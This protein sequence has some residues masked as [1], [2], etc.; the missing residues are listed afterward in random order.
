MKNYLNDK[1]RIIIIGAILLLIILAF[2]ISSLLQPVD[3][4]QAEVKKFVIPKGQAISIIGE[5]LKDEGFIKSAYAFRYI[6]ARDDLSTKI[7]AGS[8]DLSPNMSVSEIAKHLT[9]GTED[10]WITILEGWR[11]EEIAASLAS[12]DLENF[13]ED[14]FLALAKDSEG[15]LYPDTYLIPREMTASQIYNLLINTFER[16]ITLGLKDEIESS[17]KDFDQILIMA[18][19]LEREARTPDQMRRVAGILWNRIEIGM[20][21]QVDATLQYAKGYDELNQSWWV[22]P[23]S[24]DKQLQSPYN[25]YLNPGLPPKPISN[26]GL[27]AIKAAMDPL[28]SDDIFYIHSDDGM[29]YYSQ[30]L[31]GHNANINKYLR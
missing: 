9:V 24:A 18:S 16:K 23:T 25:T 28:V 1:L 15:M 26:P 6:V 8:F 13:Q 7:Q 27:S 19:L 11:A 29:M 31:E 17:Q 10:V 22:A 5:R 21:L 14:E 4:N 30:T 3:V 20:A 2:Y 12:Q